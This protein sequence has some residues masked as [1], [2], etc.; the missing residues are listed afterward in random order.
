MS[1]VSMLTLALP[2]VPE[3]KLVMPAARKSAASSNC[4]AGFEV[5][6]PARIWLPVIAARP[7]LPAGSRY[8]PVRTSTETLTSGS[9]L[10]STA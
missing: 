4:S 9:A 2:C 5:V 3:M 6:P 8:E 7:S 1:F 10:S